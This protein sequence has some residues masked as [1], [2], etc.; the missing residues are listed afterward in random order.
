M[1]SLRVYH[2]NLM[3]SLRVAHDF[4]GTPG[5][6][7]RIRIGRD[8]G[9][10]LV[11][12]SPY[13]A[14]LAAVLQGQGSRWEVL[15][16]GKNGCRVG[17]VELGPGE[18]RSVEP[19]ESIQLF[20]Y[21]LS[22]DV[23]GIAAPGTRRD[24]LDLRMSAAIKEIHTD[25]LTRIHTDYEQIPEREIDA[26]LH[27]LE[28]NLADVAAIRGVLDVTSDALGDHLAGHGLRAELLNRL[29]ARSVGADASN[30][31]SFWNRIV[32]TT[33]ERE[34]EL[35]DLIRYLADR[36][37][38]DF[39]GDFGA[40]VRLVEEGFW[41]LWESVAPTLDDE[42]RQ[43]LAL[44]HLKKEIKDVVF[45]FGPLEDLLRTPTISEI[46]VVD[47]DRIFVER[48]GL[49]ENSGRR[50]VSDAVTLSIIE[51]IVARVG[52]RIDKSQPLVD[53]RLPDG[54]RVNAVIPPLA[55]SGPCLTIRK[56]GRRRPKLDDLIEL[57]TLTRP[58]ATFLKAAVL[59]RRNIVISGGTG[60][61]KTTLLNGLSDVIP[62]RER[63]VTVEDT[64][65]LDLQ[66]SHVV[67]L[68]TKD[69]NIEG[70]GAY[71]IR[72]LV[73]NALRMRPDRIIVG[74][75]R[76]GE[77]LDMLQAMNTGHDGSLTTIHANSAADTIL[78]LE[79]L[80]QMAAD[81]PVASI[82]R[83][84]ASA[85]DLVVQL[86]R[87]RDGRRRVVQISEFAGYDSNAAAIRVKDLFLADSDET[88]PK[89]RPTGSLPG[90]MTELVRSASLSLETFYQ[91]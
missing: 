32:S 73:R 22:M 8:P 10:D 72:D 69:R 62:D 48:E 30:P 23:R 57:G 31:G 75:C 49:V 7:L 88:S 77:A 42:L 86:Q 34:R 16:V 25:L 13:V 26:A 46:M 15:A 61:G 36:L 85:I 6:P 60:S 55:V 84:I 33:P 65:E 20:P 38:L 40:Q 87:G 83:Q 17:D 29:I 80:V 90:F 19:H 39:S 44:R 91:D 68:E 18:R 51:R 52:R 11:L 81:L 67:R 4:G 27:E 5:R 1:S 56:F 12:E 64:A 70:A 59:A 35:D 74:E 89:L 50:F 76:S 53:A 54:S 82:H 37:D 71:T 45:G 47:S 41:T 78:R 58:A 79:V 66:K 2:S 9:N 43:Y 3:D 14:P 63:I 28:R 21:S 24:Q